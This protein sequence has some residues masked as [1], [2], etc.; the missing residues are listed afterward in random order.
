MKGENN[1][2]EVVITDEKQIA[3]AKVI[4]GDNYTETIK[5]ITKHENK[6]LLIILV[7]TIMHILMTFISIGIT[8]ML[9]LSF[10]FMM[11]PLSFVLVMAGLSLLAGNAAAAG[12]VYYVKDDSQYT[13]KDKKIKK[14]IKKAEQ[15]VLEKIKD[16]AIDNITPPT[17]KA[18]LK[19]QGINISNT[20]AEKIIE[21]TNQ[22]RV[23]TQG[24]ANKYINQWLLKDQYMKDIDNRSNDI[25]NQIQDTDLKTKFKDS[26]L[27]KEISKR[28]VKNTLKIK[29]ESGLKK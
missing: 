14:D 20:E 7:Q 17:L 8:S 22:S 6:K 26:R 11:P 15:T 27:V 28:V 21:I 24:D 23:K 12:F 1:D 25:Q 19:E 13:S 29:P 4:F 9:T 3:L 2:T 5:E 18:K 16:A 10:T